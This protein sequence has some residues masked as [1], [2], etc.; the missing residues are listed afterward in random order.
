MN[1]P[2]FKRQRLKHKKRLKDSWKHPRGI[3]SRQRKGVRGKGARPKIGYGTPKTE[4]PMLIR[5][6]K[7]LENAKDRVVISARI[8]RKKKTEI[9]QKAQEKNLEV[10][11]Q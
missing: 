8:G 11:N 7:D 10:L 4:Q 6:E 3:D 2:R 5:N 1:K 9:L